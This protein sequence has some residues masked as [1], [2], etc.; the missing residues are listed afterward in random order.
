MKLATL[1]ALVWSASLVSAR[2]LEKQEA[3]Q[4]VINKPMGEPEPHYLIEFANGQ[5]LWV[6]EAEKRQLKMVVCPQLSGPYP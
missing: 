4:V 1:S 6:T 3:D 5:A 2:F